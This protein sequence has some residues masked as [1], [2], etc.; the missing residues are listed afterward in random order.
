MKYSTKWIFD[1]YNIIYVNHISFSVD[2][3]YQYHPN[4]IIRDRVINILNSTKNLHK[5]GILSS[6]VDAIFQQRIISYDIYTKL[7]ILS[8]PVDTLLQHHP[9][10]VS[11]YSEISSPVF[12]IDSSIFRLLCK[13]M[14]ATSNTNTPRTLDPI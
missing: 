3:L 14:N 11:Q 2:G 13:S 1:L 6:P 7:S 12:V 5:I 8:S 9:D 10:N 4:K